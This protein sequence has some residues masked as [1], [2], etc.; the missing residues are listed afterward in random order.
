MPQKLE[1]ALDFAA[2]ITRARRCLARWLKEERR[3]LDA[4]LQSRAAALIARYFLH[5]EGVN[6]ALILSFLRHYSGKKEIDLEDPASVRMEL[7]SVLDQ[8]APAA[9]AA[10][11]RWRAFAAGAGIALALLAAW[12]LSTATITR[13][14]QA[15]LKS[16]VG[17]ISASAGVPPAALWA[18]IK[19][20][21]GVS[22]Y[23]DILWIHYPRARA[24]LEKKRA[25]HAP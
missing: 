15:E 6:D 4:A 18:E 14:Q 5:E 13:G 8:A 19:R 3:H 23:E 11:S 7:K 10:P 16:L 9:R 22:R 20:P 21:L 25:G 2:P 17:E 24:V 12:A 1:Q